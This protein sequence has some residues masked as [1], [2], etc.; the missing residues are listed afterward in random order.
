MEC[1]EFARRKGEVY[2]YNNVCLRTGMAYI[3]ALLLM[4]MTNEEVFS[5]IFF[6]QL[7]VTMF[8]LGRVLVDFDD[9]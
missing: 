4:H 2:N 7:V 9:I 5:T 6:G 1:T 3:A 8:C